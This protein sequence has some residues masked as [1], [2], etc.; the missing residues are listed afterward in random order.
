MLHTHSLAWRQASSVC[1]FDPPFPES[2]TASASQLCPAPEEGEY[3][4]YN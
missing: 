1:E 2:S 3:T 4:E